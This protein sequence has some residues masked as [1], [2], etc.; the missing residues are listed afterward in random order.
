MRVFHL[1]M[2]CVNNERIIFGLQV[3]VLTLADE[4]TLRDIFML[5]KVSLVIQYIRLEAH[6]TILSLFLASFKPID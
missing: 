6:L 4:Y 5:S 2:I 1:N 3:F